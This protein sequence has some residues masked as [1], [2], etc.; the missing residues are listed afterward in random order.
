MKKL[1]VSGD[2]FGMT[3]GINRG[4]LTG[5]NSGIITSTSLIATM[6]AFEHAVEMALENSDMDVGIHV[7][8]TL[9][10]PCSDNDR[11]LPILGEGKFVKSY[12]KFFESIYKN[13]IDLKD[14]KNEVSEQIKKIKNTGLKVTHLNSHQHIHMLPCLF[15]VIRELMK[16]HKIPFVRIPNELIGIQKIK[17]LRWLELFM[18]GLFSKI[19]KIKFIQSEVNSA[20]YFWGLSCSEALSLVDLM[21]ILKSLK[22]GVNEL[23]CHPGYEDHT[24]HQIYA[25]PFFREEELNALTS[26]KPSDFIKENSIQ[27]ISHN[28]L[29]L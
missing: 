1:I 6:P 12:R 16:E 10:R 25:D 28:E 20:D 4:I 19:S 22:Y 24:F 27:L 17:S 14:I 23:M 21:H 13:R 7:S 9:G 5:F 29:L 11:L 15:S 2:D 26:R 18:L 8:L 3:E